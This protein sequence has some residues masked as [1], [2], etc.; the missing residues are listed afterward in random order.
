MHLG[1]L[2]GGIRS[3]YGF[4]AEDLAFLRYLRSGLLLL[5]LLV[6]SN[7]FRKVGRQRSVVLSL[8]TELSG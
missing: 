5:P 8:L 7:M 2:H 1:L 4:S 3:G 6:L